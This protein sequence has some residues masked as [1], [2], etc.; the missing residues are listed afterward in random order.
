MRGIIL[1]GGHG[2][3]LRPITRLINKNLLPVYDKPAIVYAIE[4]FREAGVSRIAIIAEEHYIPEFLQVI[5]NGSNYDV[6]LVYLS[7]TEDKKGPAQALAHARS[8]AGG[9]PVA[10]IAAD[11]IFQLD[12][13]PYVSKFVTGAEMFVKPV[14]N[15]S[16]YGIA[17]VNR[18]GQVMELEEKPTH[19]RSHLATPILY[20]YD[21]SVFDRIDTI[22]PGL[23]GEYYLVDVNRSYMKEG[24]LKAHK[25]TSYWQDVG[26]FEG[27]AK[28]SY[29]WYQQ[30][31]HTPRDGKKAVSKT[32]VPRFTPK[33]YRL[34]FEFR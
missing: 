31:H 24:R 29:Y 1:A 2:S 22:Q 8:F 11:N 10:V 15:P 34:P 7:D 16:A 23:G 19:P 12:L 5:G 3:R 17:V 9:D 27:L 20:F 30:S 18:H 33:P 13:K 26:T 32:A 4:L 6:S 21:E 14:A 28:A 25:L